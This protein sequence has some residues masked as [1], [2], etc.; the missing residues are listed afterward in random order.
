MGRHGQ[1]KAILVH[2]FGTF[3][4]LDK[5][6][7]ESLSERQ[8]D[9]D[10]RSETGQLDWKRIIKSRD[11]AAQHI[12]HLI[13]DGNRTKLWSDP[14]HPLGI[15]LNHFGNRPRYNISPNANVSSII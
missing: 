9:M 3:F 14:W 5:M 15:L 6:E 11:I 8:F 12:I 10:C 7:Q 4:S 1:V 2:C 13:G